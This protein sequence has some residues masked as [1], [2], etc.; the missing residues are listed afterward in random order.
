MF[1]SFHQCRKQPY[2]TV[3]LVLS[4]DYFLG[5]I[6]PSQGGSVIYIGEGELGVT[7]MAWPERRWHFILLPFSTFMF[8]YFTKKVIWFSDLSS[9]KLWGTNTLYNVLCQLKCKVFFSPRASWW[10]AKGKARG[11]WSQIHSIRSEF[12]LFQWN[13]YI[14]LLIWALPKGKM[15]SIFAVVPEVVC[16]FYKYFFLVETWQLLYPQCNSAKA[17][18]RTRCFRLASANAD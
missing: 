9:L 10:K 5:A 11:T 1:W 16:W 14:S 3:I 2:W 12:N 8:L 4:I 6:L 13:K 15:L 17:V 18:Q 7:C